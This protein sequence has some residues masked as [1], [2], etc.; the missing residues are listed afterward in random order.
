MKAL[1]LLFVMLPGL[2]ADLGA[3]EL[4]DYP[5]QGKQYQTLTC[6]FTENLNFGNPFD[7][8]T[9]RVEL[10][11]Q[12]P[13]FTTRV[14]SFFY[15]GRN[16]DSVEKWEARFTPKQA[17]I[18]RFSVTVNGSSYARFDVPVKPNNE[19]KQGGLVLSGRLG[20]FAYESGEAFRGIGLN[21]CW[22]DDYE[23][24]FKKM[25]RAGV[26]VARIWMCPWHLSFE[27]QETGLGRYNLE[28]AARL[29]T[30]LQLSQRY[31]MYIILCMDYH[32]VARKGW[33]YFREN[34]WTTN[35]YNAINGGPCATAADLF[36][37]E[38][39][40]MFLKRRYKYIIARYG[41]SSHI[42]AWEFYNET[43]LMAG[44]SIPV[45]RWHIE[46]AEYVHS[47]D[48]HDRLVSS[49]STRRYPEK[50]IEAFKSPAMD[51]VMYHDYNTLNLGPYI[52]DFHEA[53]TE[54]YGKPV[55]LAEFGVEFRSSER[56]VRV[57][58]QHVGVH[59]GLWTGWFSETPI[60]P[61]SWW[62]D[63]LIDPYDLWSEFAN[64]SRFSERLNLNVQRLTFRTLTPGFRDT[65]PQQQVQCM[66][67]CVYAGEN[68]ALWFK[69]DEYQW[70]DIGE[71]VTPGE[72]SGFSQ[73]VP[74]VIPGRY[75]IS[76]Y[77]PQRGQFSEKT[78][79]GEVKEDRMLVLS[80]PSFSKDLACVLLRW[81]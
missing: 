38:R 29:D 63:N 27:W 8:E 59:N 76:W 42:A 4:I 23:Y 52:T 48:A 1:L 21:V 3:A 34:R 7:L 57:D 50:M 11:I 77:D 68:C 62:W 65:I 9:N 45:N 15:D 44:Q 80:V 49:S 5:T 13:D 39:A 67:R 79:D 26:N 58:P 22:A 81:H 64:L 46:M 31:G 61:M 54:Y 53:A 18:H 36:T 35:P 19:K 55:V 70:S 51:F 56:T 66:I 37:N 28:S 30:I 16:R 10:I 43:D 78:V 24:Y 2:R 40:K 25:Q 60:I 17:G 12:Q 73:T 47:I 14:L 33:G 20:T 74:N 75:I 32:G 69:N 41:H 72:V 71:G 6:R